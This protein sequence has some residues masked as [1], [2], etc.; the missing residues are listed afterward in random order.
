MPDEPERSNAPS[1]L[2]LR[3]A[4]GFAALLFLHAAGVEGQIDLTGVEGQIDL[5]VT[6]LAVSVEQDDACP[7]R[8][9]LGELEDGTY[10]PIVGVPKI[11]EER[12][13]HHKVTWSVKNLGPDHYHNSYYTGN[14]SRDNDY[15]VDHTVATSLEDLD[16]SFSVSVLRTGRRA[17]LLNNE[18]LDALAAQ[19]AARGESTL[20]QLHG[21]TAFLPPLP[22]GGVAH[23]SFEHHIANPLPNT[24]LRDYLDAGYSAVYLTVCVLEQEIFRNS[25]RLPAGS[26]INP[27]NNC[28]AHPL[29]IRFGVLEPLPQESN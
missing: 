16:P 10:G 28:A 21:G 20:A 27:D 24:F 14:A 26:D 13:L 4:A 5:T 1:L 23:G 22:P 7:Y 2:L 12:H 29:R 6:N 11:E 25:T 3:A 8:W 18:A 15:Y 9:I 19:R 17:A